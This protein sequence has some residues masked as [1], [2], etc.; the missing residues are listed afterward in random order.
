MATQ[1]NAAAADERPARPSRIGVVTSAKRSKT[2]TVTV[3]YSVRHAKYNK[4]TKR[5]TVLHAHDERGEA[6]LGDTV[7]IVEC[8]PLSKTKNWRLVRVLT[9]APRE[10]AGAR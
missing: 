9:Q 10:T 6:G 4:Y 5:R 7:E 8:R 2:I 1:Q 3:A